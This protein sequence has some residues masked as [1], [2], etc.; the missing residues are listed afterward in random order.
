MN[1]TYE[2]QFTACWTLR[3]RVKWVLYPDGSTPSHDAWVVV[4]LMTL[5]LWQTREQR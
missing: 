4:R 5:G 2:A 1:I 3:P